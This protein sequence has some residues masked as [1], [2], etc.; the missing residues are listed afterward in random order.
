MRKIIHIITAL[1]LI[2][3]TL[4]GCRG[5]GKLRF[6]GE[7]LSLF[8]TV[9]RVVAYTD[10][11]KQFD[12]YMEFMRSHLETYHKLFDIYNS[13][14]GIPNI[15]TINDNAG[16]SA[17]EVDEKLIDM[18]LY[19]KEIYAITEGQTNIAM[20]SVLS[21]WHDYRE[22]GID[23]PET[24]KLP[25]K[26]ELT[27]AALH[28]NPD[29]IIIDEEKNTVFLRDKEMLLDVGAIAKGYAVEMA[30]KEAES[31]G[32]TNLLISVG[33]NVRAIGNRGDGTPWSVGIEGIKENGKEIAVPLGDSY[34]LVTSGD[35]QRYYTVDGESYCH[36]IDPKTLFPPRYFS[37]VTVMASDSGLADGLSTALF[38]L[39]LEE[40][41]ALLEALGKTQ[42]LEAVWLLPSGEVIYS[43][44]T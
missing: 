7:F 40:G 8:D 44:L 1:V 37:A 39:S 27:R 41:R 18:L 4:S 38:T 24:A 22:R 35:Y 36:I 11:R 20:G 17:A 2:L 23:S 34:S 5:G 3:T 12:E 42:T 43:K 31:D 26:E 25:P 30:C 14:E 16:V 10:S 13:Y 6:E 32:I 9:T 33:G 19:A 28:T 29:D 21:I 15:K